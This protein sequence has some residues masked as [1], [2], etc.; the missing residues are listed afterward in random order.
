MAFRIAVNKTTAMNKLHCIVRCTFVSLD[1]TFDSS[2]S[3]LTSTS[4]YS[5]NLRFAPSRYPA[6][7]TCPSIRFRSQSSDMGDQAAPSTVHAND[8]PFPLTDVDRWVLSQTDEEF[9]RHSWDELREIIDTNN[10]S[11]LKRTP[12]DLR[13]YM[14]WTAETKAQYGS[15]SA[16]ILQ[17]RLPSSWQGPPFTPASTVPFQDP[18]DYRAL[19][20]DWP[21]GLDPEITH[22]V[23]WSRTLIPVD[24]ENGD[25]TSES[26]ELVKAFVKSYFVDRLGEG[27]EGR[28]LWFKNWVSL[29]SVRSLEHV[30]VLVRGVSDDI[31]QEWTGDKPSDVERRRRQIS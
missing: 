27:G 26:R 20:N 7:Q 17:K 19:L 2:N 5:Q 4:L 22:I 3:P 24:D 14:K 29:Q 12:S 15:M 21:Y 30:H 6:L 28:V 13:Q 16:Y 23:V 1:P 18:S 10:L 8:S 11:V 25:L 9:K 31:L